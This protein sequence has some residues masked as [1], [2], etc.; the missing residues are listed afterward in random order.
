MGRD[1]CPSG[2]PWESQFNLR[3]MKRINTRWLGLLA[4]T[5]IALY[6]CW[7]II[8]PFVN[9]IL[10]ALVLAIIAYPYHLKLRQRN[11]GP[12]PAALISTLGVIVV[13][14][15][16]V[17]MIL[18]S[19]TS[20]IPNGDKIRDLVVQAK[21]WVSPDSRLYKIVDPYVDLDWMQNPVLV[22]ERT[23]RLVAPL[24]QHFASFATAAAGTV[25]STAVQVAFALFTL[26]YLLRDGVSIGRS[27][28]DVL[29]LEREQ[30]E[31]VWQRCQDVIQASV[32]GVLM[33]AAIQGALGGL[34]FWALGIPSPI[35]WGVVMFILSMV[36]A[37]GAFLVW[38]PA[39][40]FLFA[41]GHWAKA[42]FMIAWG[43]VVIGSI[44][45]FLRPRLVGQKTGMHDLVIFFSVLGGLQ[46][47]GILGLFV[48]PVVVGISL[49][50][51]EVFKH[52]SQNWRAVDGPKPIGNDDAPAQN[53]LPDSPVDVPSPS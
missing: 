2:D 15:V 27:V 38:G 46:V 5:L 48:G 47:F 51:V 7:L 36:P 10:W 14:L 32:K 26:F 29:P 44:D 24:T 31:K 49:A 52:A 30:S 6:L 34:A 37:L 22:K 3:T 17:L 16:P 42:I 28:A 19:L 33:I 53:Q 12:T 1:F 9:V 39:A 18:L 41:T 13:V 4:I 35:L 11:V 21:G 8:L 45:N 23:Q 43:G 20:Q 25:A 40:V 50:I